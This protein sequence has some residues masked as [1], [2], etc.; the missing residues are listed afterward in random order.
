MCFMQLTVCFLQ[1]TAFFLQRGCLF[2]SFATQKLHLY[3]RDTTK[4][5]APLPMRLRSCCRSTAIPGG[6]FCGRN[7]AMVI[8]C[9]RNATMFVISGRNAATPN[10]FLR[11]LG[12]R[13]CLATN[14]SNTSLRVGVPIS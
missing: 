9:G 11:L 7:A 3:K 5:G 6:D 10:Y 1:K 8:I 4:E 14:S 2:H 12:L 13:L